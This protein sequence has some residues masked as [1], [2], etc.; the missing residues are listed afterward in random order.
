MQ[1]QTNLIISPEIPSQIKEPIIIGQDGLS[2][3]EF[4]PTQTT[5]LNLPAYLGGGKFDLEAVDCNHTQAITVEYLLSDSL[6]DTKNSKNFKLLRSITDYIGVYPDIAIYDTVSV[7]RAIDPLVLKIYNKFDDGRSYD[8]SEAEQAFLDR[9][10]T[11]VELVDENESKRFVALP[12]VEGALDPS[13]LQLKRL[14]AKRSKKARYFGALGITQT[15][16]DAAKADIEKSA[17]NVEKIILSMNEPPEPVLTKEQ[18]VIEDQI[19]AD[20]LAVRTVKKERIIKERFESNDYQQILND[21]GSSDIRT[22]RILA[23]IL[24]GIMPEINDHRS[25]IDALD[26]LAIRSSYMFEGQKIDSA[27]FEKVKIRCRKVLDGH[28]FVDDLV[29]SGG[30]FDSA[31]KGRSI[32]MI[33]REPRHTHGNKRSPITSNRRRY[34]TPEA[35]ITEKVG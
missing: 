32:G 10:N 11:L 23:A 6:K 1:T 14:A 3:Q 4:V 9:F 30:S 7:L 24:R 5:Q 34:T 26:A 22:K 27:I 8:V 21:L 12:P 18:Q 35:P 20:K 16:K 15:A 29:A 19:I 31:V 13:V 25:A 33:H 17:A 2:V 28:G